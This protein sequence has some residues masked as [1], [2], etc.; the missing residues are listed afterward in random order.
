MT[1]VIKSA[2]CLHDDTV[3]ATLKHLSTLIPSLLQMSF[4]P[5]AAKN[6]PNFLWHVRVSWFI[7]WRWCMWLCYKKAVLSLLP[8][9]LSTLCSSIHCQKNEVEVYINASGCVSWFPEGEKLDKKIT[10]RVLCFV[11]RW[12]TQSQPGTSNTVLV[13]V[14]HW[15]IDW[16]YLLALKPWDPTGS[17]SYLEAV[18]CFTV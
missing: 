11:E 12:E 14:Y 13:N 9:W 2:F 10:K 6:Q 3:H 5:S 7:F 8:C 1:V 18:A 17:P 15:S 4:K 16:N